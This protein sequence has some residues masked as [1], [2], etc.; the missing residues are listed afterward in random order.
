MILAVVVTF[1]IRAIGLFLVTAMLVVPT[2]TARNL[3]QG[4]SGLFWGALICA[5]ISG[6]AGSCFLS[7]GTRRP[8]RPPY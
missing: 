5:M 2:A 6:I 8:E 4:I 7:I 3:A 1:S